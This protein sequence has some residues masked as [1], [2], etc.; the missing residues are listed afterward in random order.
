MIRDIESMIGEKPK[1][2]WAIFV[3]SWNFICP[4][5]LT[6]NFFISDSFKKN[7]FLFF[8]K[9]GIIVLTMVFPG[10]PMA[11]NEVVLPAWANALG[12]IIAAIPLITIVACAAAQIYYYECNWVKL[13]KKQCK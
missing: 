1:W 12:W 6:V 9:K 11:V 7:F 5:M 3:I 13:M 4:I 2:L 10:E 8:I